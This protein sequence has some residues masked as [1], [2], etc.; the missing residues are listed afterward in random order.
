MK[1]PE[2]Q[3]VTRNKEVRTACPKCGYHWVFGAG[4]PLKDTQ[5]RAIIR[6]ASNNDTAYFTKN[7]LYAAYVAR[8]GFMRPATVL[9]G[10]GLIFAGLVAVLYAA[11]APLV[12]GVPF[13]F[14]AAII[15]YFVFRD[16][17]MPQLEFEALLRKWKSRNGN[18][19]RLL[20][21]SELRLRNP[22]P[23]YTEADIFSYGVENVLIVDRDVLVD[24]FVLN[25]FATREKTLIVSETGYPDYIENR[26]LEIL[27]TQPDVPVYLL[28]DATEVGQGM[29]RRALTRWPALRE[30]QVRDLGLST[31]DVRKMRQFRRFRS[32]QPAAGMPLDYLSAGACAS[33]VAAAISARASLL[34]AAAMHHH[35][36]GGSYG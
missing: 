9:L 36:G 3:T 26:L 15:W 14:F 7:Q 19:E 2:C 18:P 16:R 34:D 10:G 13:G 5:F 8:V 20:L 27:K 23:E 30:N 33:L 11:E 29:R 35:G 6:K 28:H 31:E 25:N 17:A 12:L 22:P 24:F 4:D 21:D 32:R 1:G